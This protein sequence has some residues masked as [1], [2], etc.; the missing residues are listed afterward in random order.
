MASKELPDVDV[1]YALKTTGSRSFPMS[2]ICHVCNPLTL[3]HSR[4]FYMDILSKPRLNFSSNSIL[5][6][7]RGVTLNSTRAHVFTK[8][9]SDIMYFVQFSVAGAALFLS[10]TQLSST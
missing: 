10:K 6:L 8:N 1:F 7:V 2:A 9:I 5:Y 4:I 3:V